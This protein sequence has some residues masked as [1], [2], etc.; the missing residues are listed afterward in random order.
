[1]NRL[2]GSDLEVN[3]PMSLVT[4]TAMPGMTRDAIFQ[5]IKSN[6]QKVLFDIDPN[7]ITVDQ[8]LVALGANSVDR[9]EVVM[10]SMEELNLSIP[11]VELHGIENLRGL[12][13]VFHKHLHPNG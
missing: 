12:V 6:V 4:K 2:P 10:Y 3:P 5:V 9:V 1:M 7:L 11:R 13:E 8:S